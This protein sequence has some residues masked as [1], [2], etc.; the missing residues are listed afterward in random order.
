[1]EVLQYYANNQWDF[2]N[3]HAIII[4]ARMTED[5]LKKFKVDAKGVDIYKYFE[6]C[7]LGGR[8]YL[9]KQ[10]D[11]M[12]PSA[13]R[14]MKVMW[15][16]DRLCK[17]FIYGGLLYWLMKKLLP[18]FFTRDSLEEFYSSFSNAFQWQSV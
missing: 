6:N 10:S 8:R 12:L 2:D 17:L 4:R 13:R 16:I 9:L 7:I 1:M 18:V 11:D 14:M 3:K 5:E 15:A